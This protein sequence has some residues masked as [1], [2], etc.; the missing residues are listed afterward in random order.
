VSD[1]RPAVARVL[2]L[3]AERL[4]AY[5][6]GDELAFE[7]VGER[8]EEARISGEDLQSAVL[9]LKSM[10]GDLPEEEATELSAPAGG[11]HRVL[12]D[13]ER[14][15]LSP[16]AWGT[17]LGLRRRGAL[18]PGQFERVLDMLGGSGVRPVDV[19]FALE[20]AS[21]VALHGDSPDMESSHGE[22]D[23]SH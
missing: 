4:D 19:D 7:T 23:V 3:L 18:T 13:E 12:S 15:A 21:R 2:R 14:G 22:V 9:V 11:S 17:L 5:L 1:E 6:E 16:E 20:I 10:A 8:L